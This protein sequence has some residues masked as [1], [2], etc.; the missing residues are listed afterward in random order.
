MLNAKQI[1]NYCSFNSGVLIGNKDGIDNK[2]I[3]KNYVSFGPS[4]K[5]FGNITIGENVFIAPGAVVTK[6]IEDNSIAGGIPA[7]IIKKKNI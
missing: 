3:L 4:A 6:D 7:K 5:A 1:G 2:P